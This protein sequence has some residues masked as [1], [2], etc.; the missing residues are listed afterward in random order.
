MS[1]EQEARDNAVTREEPRKVLVSLE[2][3][4]ALSLRLPSG[5]QMWSE[6]QSLSLRAPPSG[7]GV[8][9]GSAVFPNPASH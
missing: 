3:V 2:A 8:E 5:R 1:R 6:D 9:H 7:W 4:L